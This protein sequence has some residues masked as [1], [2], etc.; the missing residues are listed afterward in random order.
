MNQHKFDMTTDK[1]DDDALSLAAVV[2]PGS[3]LAI[4]MSDKDAMQTLSSIFI[5]KQMPRNIVEVETKIRTMCSYESLAEKAFFSYDRGPSKI[6]G[7]TIHL[8]NACMAAYGNIEAGWRKT[9]ETVNDKGITCSCCEAYC[10]DKENNIIRKASFIVPHWRE[11]KNNKEGGYALKS[12]RDIYEL[13][14]N[15]ASRRM[16]ACIFGV[17]PEFVKELA[18]EQCKKTLEK[19]HNSME[20]SM[21]SLKEKFE[22]MGVTI[23]MLEKKVGVASDKWTKTNVIF[24]RNLFNALRTGV[25]S[26]DDQFGEKKEEQKDNKKSSEPVFKKKEEESSIIDTDVVENPN[27]LFNEKEGTPFD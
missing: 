3:A 1:K 24:L 9:G 13:C 17:I 4:A 14:A 5:A 15:M 27:D 26:V 25:C 18:A 6:T 11:T 16:R 2:N 19:D 10:F 22:Q 7:E 20:E 12:D 23:E 21:A 8:A